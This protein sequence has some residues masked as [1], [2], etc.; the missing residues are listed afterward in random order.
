M[1]KFD[2]IPQV[3]W[4]QGESLGLL[5]EK[6]VAAVKFDRD[7]QGNPCD[8][9]IIF[10]GEKLYFLCGINTLKRKKRNL[11]GGM[12]LKVEY[13]SL[14]TDVISAEGWKDFKV[15]QFISFGAVTA[16]DKDGGGV[17]VTRISRGDMH[18]AEGFCFDVNETLGCLPKHAR[19]PKKEDLACCPK[20]GKPYPDQ[21]RRVCPKCIDRAGV[22]K[23][24]W[25]FSKKYKWSIISIFTAMVLASMLTVL[26][27]YISS[28]FF[29]DS[30]L[31]VGGKYYGQVLLV[32]GI[33]V[34]TKLLSLLINMVNEVVTAI[35]VPKIIYDLK[36][37]IFTSIEKLS[38]SFFTN[39][40]TGSLMN[41]VNGDAN[42]IY[43]FFVEAL[44]SIIINSV[45]TVT[46]FIIM[47]AIE[48]RLTLVAV[49]VA[50]LAVFLSKL[51]F[52]RMNKLHAKRYSRAR[53]LNGMLTDALNAVR[54]VKAF[55]RE[56]EEKRRFAVRNK[57]LAD[58]DMDVSLDN[59]TLFS[60]VTY[61]FTLAGA[62]LTG[63][64]GWLVIKGDMTYGIFVTFTAYAAM[65]FS[66][67]NTFVNMTSSISNASNAM[68]RLMEVMDAEPEVK[69]ADEPVHLER[70]SGNI[71]FKNVEFSYVKNRKIIDGISFKISPGETLG[72]VGHTGAGKSTV[73]NLLIRLYDVNEGEILVD[74][75][76]I[77]DIS[78]DTLRRNIAIVSQETYLFQGTIFDNIAYA[79]PD[80][81][82]EEVLRAARVSGAHDFICKLDDG[83]S[84]KIGWGY[85]DLS[86]GE[87][88]RISIA[89]ALLRDPSILILDEAT[90]AMD[91]RTE[92]RIQSALEKLSVGRTTITIAHRLSTLR[93]ADRL[94]VLEN[95]KFP[96]EGTHGEL[97]RQKGIYYKLYMLQYEALKNAGIEEG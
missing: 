90:S 49:A 94:M 96:E 69:E 6:A 19:R 52:G 55:A 13:E 14:S 42:T 22:V 45:Q 61:L 81:T 25:L 74:G 87:K 37:T 40:Q 82:K 77:K 5:R 68:Q 54:V 18:E 33:L 31:T 12:A 73:A 23:R 78:F 28:G 56:G 9:Y 27:P 97:I 86:G 26:T 47:M 21:M 11:S 8:C 48:W 95:G 17:I 66:P 38:L 63:L 70:L 51:L 79:K 75:H 93:N 71:E 29:Y 7:R 2:K 62:V 43:W 57:A 72:I 83:Y 39:R 44:P 85:K 30:V 4:K 60:L 46:I 53:S 32:I 92:R 84:T 59:V 67:L 89:R 34:S 65:L 76:N 91:T 80:A 64:G 41:Q 1:D 15:E 88:Q 20:C 10:D 35:V 16:K 24:I 36:K 58:A 3:I 50:P